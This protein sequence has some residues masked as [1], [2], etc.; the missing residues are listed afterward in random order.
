MPVDTRSAMVTLQPDSERDEGK[1]ARG[2]GGPSRVDESV[3]VPYIDRVKCIRPSRTMILLGLALNCVGHR[4]PKLNRRK[5][6]HV[7][8]N[9]AISCGGIEADK[10]FV[11][12]RVRDPE[13]PH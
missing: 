7:N 3:R 9:L 2:R 11:R 1:A 6:R 4:H 10:V 5:R 13:G 8:P 12:V